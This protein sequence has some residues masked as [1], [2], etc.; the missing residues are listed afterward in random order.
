MNGSDTTC[1]GTNHP[2]DT[3]VKALEIKLLPEFENQAAILKKEF[4]GFAFETRSLRHVDQL[5]T[6]GLRCRSNKT[7]S[8]RDAF[9]LHIN[10]F[11]VKG[12]SARGFVGW[13]SF[14]TDSKGTGRTHFE[15]MTRSYKNLTKDNLDGLLQ[16]IP[17]LYAGLKRAIKRG[18]PPSR[19]ERIWNRH[20]HRCD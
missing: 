18:H 19:L 14:Y 10:V 2:I 13:N 5:H 4:P 1:A 11:D 7:D 16:E 3:V 8:M 6:L 17:K 15:A 12:I 20:T 9:S